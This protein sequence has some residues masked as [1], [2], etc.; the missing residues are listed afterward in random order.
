M[1]MVRTG[2]EVVE[3]VLLGRQPAVV[4]PLLAELAAAPDIGYR[5]DAALC[6]LSQAAAR[7]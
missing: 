2:D 1:Q 7:R 3:A 4:V 6:S 5:V